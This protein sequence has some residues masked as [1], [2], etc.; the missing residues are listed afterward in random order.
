MSHTIPLFRV[1]TFVVAIL[2]YTH[3]LAQQG[4]LGF[5][6]A[7]YGQR[8]PG[9]SLDM[10]F[11][12]SNRMYSCEK[13]GRVWVSINGIRANNALID[14][15]EE[16]DN[17]TDRGL[18]ALALDP[19][20]AQNGYLYLSYV[21]DRHHLL[22]YGTPAYNANTSYDGA[23]IV[24]VTRYTVSPQSLTA[25]NPNLMS[26]VPNS[27]LVLLGESKASSAVV[28][29]GSHAGG[30]LAFGA[31][32]SLLVATGD[33]AG[34]NGRDVGGSGN[35]GYG[36]NFWQ[37]ALD[38]GLM[39]FRENVGS[40]RSQLLDSHSGKILRLD[41][42]TGD[43]L[44]S[45]PYF[46]PAKPRSARS[47][48]FASGLRN[49]YRISM[50]PGTGSPNP[51]AGDPGSLYIGDVGWNR[52][53]EIH[54]MKRPGQNFGWPFYEGASFVEGRSEFY[55]VP[56]NKITNANDSTQNIYYDR[57]PDP[58]DSLALFSK[59]EIA[60]SHQSL[61]VTYLQHG[62]QVSLPSF[63]LPYNNVT[64]GA[65][66]VIDGGWTPRLSTLPE[67]YQNKYFFGGYF[68]GSITY[69]DFDE[70]DDVLSIKHFGQEFNGMNNM[71]I[72]PNNGKLYVLYGFNIDVFQV[73][74]TGNQPPV[75]SLLTNASYGT[76]PLSVSLDGS[77]SRDPEQTAITY[78][79]NFGDGSAVSTLAAP[80]HSYTATGVRSYTTTLTVTD[81]G[82]ASA[83]QS[84][85]ISV[86]NTPPTI[87]STSLDNL[88]LV[89]AT[90]TTALTLSAVVTDAEHSAAQLTYRWQVFEQHND[91]AHPEFDLSSPVSSVTLAALGPCSGLETYWY[92]VVLTVTDAAGLMTS[93]NKDI[94]PNCSGLAQTISFPTVG[95]RPLSG[96][97]FRPTVWSSSGLPVTLYVV[98]GPAYMQGGS[99]Y[100]TGRVGRVTLRALQSGNG[101][102]RPAATVERNF[103]VANLTTA[104]LALQLAFDSRVSA[105]NVPVQLQLTVT[106]NSLD[107]ASGV[108]L[109]SRLP[110]NL[111]FV[112]GSG[113]T[114]L[115]GV[116]SG[117]LASVPGGFSQT[118]DLI[119][120]PTAAGT[121][122]LS[123]E[124]DASDAFDPDSQAG[125][126][127]GDGE[128]DQATI[129]LRTP[130][131][132][133]AEWV[134][135]NPNQQPLPPLLG[136]QPPPVANKVD[137]SLAMTA[138]TRVAT[139][140]QPL[141]Q[142]LTVTNAGSLTAMNVV[143]RD[144]LRLLTLSLPSAWSVVASG[145]NYTVIEATIP[146]ITP[147]QSAS[148]SFTVFPTATGLSQTAAQI[149]SVGLPGPNSP[150]DADSIPGNGVANGEDD[151]AWLDWRVY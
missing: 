16:V 116:V 87:L 47:R 125:S 98:G 44:P 103:D 138:N 65:S 109:V 113:L 132:D 115:N 127:T 83:Q 92:R 36:S 136:N 24:R 7:Q 89:S 80:V 149:W 8:L 122:R 39:T 90:A 119:V 40:Y 105:V 96:T 100:L 123:A 17:S 11:D 43:G 144:T 135:P 81:A 121:Y 145:A 134:S 150:P 68:R 3:T 25:T 76:S 85:I 55:V 117:T 60:I 77:N 79:W 72:N 58:N 66:A 32:G 53:E 20:F 63:N 140:G 147:Q 94:Y 13:V 131:D 120:Q 48:M 141:T 143:V 74:F 41:P 57:L 110:E 15:Q 69:A 133:E 49:P 34:L 45:N 112:S 99:V 59:P 21:V 35:P 18:L 33:G 6:T 71:S 106:N 31:D 146:V 107:E 38:D 142:T 129:D 128:D 108:V 9:I 95:K 78:A 52:Y 73:A 84:I 10:D 42:T 91:H 148:L 64:N 114:Y 130:D 46:D 67:A 51:A 93:V 28:L 88:T 97:P 104:D 62:V 56:P 37:Q 101:A 22:Y 118:V 126:G 30:D 82:G 75:V 111:S 137:L 151:C 12:A 61:G 29:D 1:G 50:R 14:I 27:R 23:S 139:V 102:Y 54:V 2:L 26:V 124:I 19:N 86:N 5:E 70:D 4:P